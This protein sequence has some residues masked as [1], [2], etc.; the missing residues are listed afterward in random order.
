M[1]GRPVTDDLELLLQVMPPAVRARIE[2]HPR[3]GELVELVLDLGRLP[4]ARFPDAGEFLSD[5]MVGREDLAYVV[6]R[7]GRFGKDNR[8]GIERTLHRIS[9]I[10]NRVGDVIGLTC[11]VGRAVFG[12]VDI[13]RDVIEAGQSILLLGRPGVGKTT[14][15]REAARVLA[16]DLS[17]RVIVVDTSNEIAGDGDVPHPGIGRARRMQVPSPDEQH[18]VMIEAVENHM[19]Q[20]IVIDE[21]GTAAEA[22]A[23]RTIAERGVQLIAT[24]HG[25][26]LEN[27]LQNPTLSDLVGGIQAVTLS[28]EE[29]RRRGTQKT[30]LERKAPPT[31]GVL[32]EIQ[33]KDRLAVHHD[34]AEVVDRLLRDVPPRPELRTRTAGGA[35]EIRRAERPERPERS[36]RSERAERGPAGR[37]TPKTASPWFAAPVDPAEEDG[38]AVEGAPAPPPKAVRGK[39][40]RIFPYA[41]SKAKLDRAL[42]KFRVSAYMVDD[43]DNADMVVTLKSQEKRQPHRLRDAQARGVP[44]YVVRS[45]TIVQMENFLRSV[46]GVNDPTAGDDEAL[47][48]VEEAIDQALDQGNPVELSP[49]NNHLR[50]LQH[51]VI[52]RYGLTSESKGEEPYRRVVIYPG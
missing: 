52:E 31:F 18:G 3:R 8:A 19:P 16:D 46:F 51:Q 10:R 9:A 34:V 37:R 22:L 12:T 41:V 48:E 49:Q 39:T 26:T 11:R 25:N 32:I 43:L 6:E 50:R 17:K 28:D 42:R 29:A 35:V 36:E 20:V 33:D 1:S 30:V 15:L 14:I 23:A 2:S 24:A 21:I 7:V 27:L 40:V 45:N 38:E 5:Q 47:R 44:F 13:L 4:E